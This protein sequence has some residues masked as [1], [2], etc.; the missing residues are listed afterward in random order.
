VT[1]A[2]ADRAEDHTVNTSTVRFHGQDELRFEVGSR[3][4]EIGGEG[5]FASDGH[6]AFWAERSS[7]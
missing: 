4:A 7:Q 3:I 5:L 6:S 1:F 2:N